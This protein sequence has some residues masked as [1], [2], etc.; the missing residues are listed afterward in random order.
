MSPAPANCEKCSAGGGDDLPSSVTTSIDGDIS[1]SIPVKINY[2]ETK[3]LEL[4][5]T[6]VTRISHID[7]A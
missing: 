4:L 7:I 5:D 2:I 6:I 3:N 1:L